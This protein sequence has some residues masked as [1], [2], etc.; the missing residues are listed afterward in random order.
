M[1]T[2]RKIIESRR[3]L[4]DCRK[5]GERWTCP[6]WP[7]TGSVATLWQRGAHEGHWIRRRVRHFLKWHMRMV[8]YYSLSAIYILFSTPHFPVRRQPF[9]SSY[10]TAATL[11][12]SSCSRHVAHH[13]LLRTMGGL[14]RPG[15][16]P[17]CLRI[18]THASPSS[19]SS[20]Y[21]LSQSC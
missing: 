2:L 11:S 1:P 15:A 3:A 19:L 17:V 8:R 7:W 18:A 10:L 20:I 5:I 9:P 13:E 4:N 21:P 12:L 16:V 14:S 6:E